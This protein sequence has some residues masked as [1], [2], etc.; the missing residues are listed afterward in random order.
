MWEIVRHLF[1]LKIAA[2]LCYW[3][4]GAEHLSMYVCAFG[5]MSFIE[6]LVD[7]SGFL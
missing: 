1:A 7:E 5:N 4:G 2:V 6:I 3:W